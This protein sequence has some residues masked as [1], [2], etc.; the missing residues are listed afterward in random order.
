MKKHTIAQVGCGNRGKIH[1]KGFKDNSDRF[2][3][4]G[5]CDL[6]ETT[7][8]D[9]AEKYGIVAPL[10]TDVEKMLKETK[11]DVFCFVAPPNIRKSM[12]EFGAKHKVKGIAFE[13]PMA[14]SLKEAKNI[15]DLC[16]KNKIKA[17]VCHQHKYLKSMRKLKSIVFSASLPCPAL[18]SELTKTRPHR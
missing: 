18:P 8:K 3:L 13:K 2:E 9:A 16:N 15:A 14:T 4:V 11:P 1:I 17:V 7:L 10:Y 6:S 12:I 5:L